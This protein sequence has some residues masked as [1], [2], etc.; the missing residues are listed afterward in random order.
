MRT[1]RIRHPASGP[2][3]LRQLEESGFAIIPDVLP[4]ATVDSLIHAIEIALGNRTDSSEYAI[5]H[6]H[7]KVPAV[8]RL[9]NSAMVRA[10]VNSVLGPDGFVVRSIFFDKTPVA[11]WKVAWHQDLTIAV[12]ERIEVP[13]FAAWS[14]K[15]ALVHVQPPVSV[16]ERMVTVRFHLDDCG[17]ENGPLQVIPKSHKAGRLTGQ[18]ISACREREKS[19]ACVVP[20]GGALLMRPLLLHASSPAPTPMHRRAVHLEFACDPLPGGLEWEARV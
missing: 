7:Q 13:G 20:R 19:I 12:R 10:L 18:Q 8:R 1:I 4:A 17:P 15:D 16:L 9:A 3:T 14:I 6:L 5:R 11:N 2:P